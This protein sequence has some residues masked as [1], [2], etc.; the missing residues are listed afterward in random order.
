VAVFAAATRTV[1]TGMIRLLSALSTALSTAFHT[2]K[3]YRSILQ[4]KGDC[5]LVVIALLLVA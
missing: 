4:K 1:V 5:R 2:S 3:Q